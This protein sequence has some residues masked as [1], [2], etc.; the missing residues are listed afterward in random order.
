MCLCASCMASCHALLMTS[1]LMPDGYVTTVSDHDNVFFTGL[2]IPLL[3]GSPNWI[4]PHTTLSR[5]G[6]QPMSSLI[7]SQTQKSENYL[8]QFIRLGI[9]QH[10][11]AATYTIIERGPLGGTMDMS[12]MITMYCKPCPGLTCTHGRPFQ[13]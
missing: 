8:L 13:L 10:F 6:I 2:C 5:V 7:L 12:F 4:C 1:C 11:G 9:A 3:T